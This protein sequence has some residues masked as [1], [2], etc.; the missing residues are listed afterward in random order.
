MDA[1]AP[2]DVRH[3]ATFC[4][5]CEAA[6]GLVVSTDADRERVLRIEP[7][8]EHVVT[9]GYACVKGIHFDEIQH[10]PDRIRRPMK[11]TGP[12]PQDWKEISWEEAL[13]EIGAK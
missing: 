11:R 9:K 5:I 1:E 7:D 6:C 2:D 10:S 4:R 3:V 8:H 13:S 12:G